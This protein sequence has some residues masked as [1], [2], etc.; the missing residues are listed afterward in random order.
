MI[1]LQNQGETCYLSGSLEQQD[2]ILLWP[3]RHELIQPNIAVLDLSSLHYS[4][5][6]GV[7]FI[8]ELWRLSHAGGHTLRLTSA[9]E[10]LSKLIAL[11]D[12]QACFD[13]K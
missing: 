12:L 2:V 11:Y 4:D 13:N 1:T 9:S 3:K 5:S 7:A 10:Q 6:A 8:L